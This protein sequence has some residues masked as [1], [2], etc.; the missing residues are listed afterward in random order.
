MGGKCVKQWPLAD[1]GLAYFR[2]KGSICNFGGLTVTGGFCMAT[3]L[4]GVTHQK[5]FWLTFATQ[6]YSH[7]GPKGH[8][9]ASSKCDN[10]VIAACHKNEHFLGNMRHN[11]H[12]LKAEH[13]A[14]AF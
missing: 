11:F 1:H 4:S 3:S 9:T 5:A 2:N 6:A 7:V 14:L 8:V 12:K 13:V 10:V